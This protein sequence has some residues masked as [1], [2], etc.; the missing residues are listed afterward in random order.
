[1]SG[2]LRSRAGDLS[3]G[4]D[5]TLESPRDYDPISSHQLL[6]PN[7][8]VMHAGTGAHESERHAPRLF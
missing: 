6:D 4:A 1:M 2:G 7:G 5:D 3:L 8:A